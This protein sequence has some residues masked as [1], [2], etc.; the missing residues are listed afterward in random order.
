[1]PS[2]QGLFRPLTVFL[3]IYTSKAYMPCSGY[4]PNPTRVLSARARRVPPRCA[5]VFWRLRKPLYVSPLRHIAVRMRCFRHAEEALWQC[6]RA[7]SASSLR[8]FRD[9]IQPFRARHKASSVSPFARRQVLGGVS[10]LPER[11]FRVFRFSLSRFSVVKIFYR[12][13]MHIYAFI[14]FPSHVIRCSPSVLRRG[15]DEEG[16]SVAM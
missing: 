14:R 3:H 4:P 13:L 16:C 9:V 11:L 12:R 6:E 15:G 5:S 10:R 2:S 7:S 8:L 1:M